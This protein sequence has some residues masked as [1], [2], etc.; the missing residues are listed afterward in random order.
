[1]EI[2]CQDLA[3]TFT[4]AYDQLPQDAYDRL[5]EYYT[6][7]DAYLEQDDLAEL[8]KKTDMH[9]VARL[10]WSTPVRD[11]IIRLIKIH[12]TSKKF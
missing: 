12:H 11:E 5:M 10:L 1:M 6:C 7:A 3:T 8:L 4:T 9:R 2:Y